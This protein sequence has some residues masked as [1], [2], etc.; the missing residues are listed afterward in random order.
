MVIQVGFCL[1]VSWRFLL[2]AFVVSLCWLVCGKISVFRVRATRAEVDCLEPFASV[3]RLESRLGFRSMRDTIFDWCILWV[4]T[5]RSGGVHANVRP[6]AG[7]WYIAGT[8]SGR[9][10]NRTVYDNLFLHCCTMED[11]T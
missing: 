8:A 5:N 2:G 3:A 9:P 7:S 10:P 4:C 1:V 6:R 11:Y